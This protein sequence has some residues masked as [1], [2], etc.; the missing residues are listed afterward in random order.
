MIL[1]PSNRDVTFTPSF[2]VFN[3]TSSLQSLAITSNETGIKLIRYSISGPN[4]VEFAPPGND[5]IFV[6]LITNSTNRKIGNSTSMNLK[7]PI[8]CNEMV[9]KKCMA[10]NDVIV[11][12]STT[13]WENTGLVTSSS[14]V[15]VVHA[16]KMDFPM[17]LLGAS[18]PR[19]AQSLDEKCHKIHNS[20]VE[21][22]ARNQI[23][24][25]TFLDS[26]K[27]SF[28]KWLRV[29]LRREMRTKSVLLSDIRTQFLSGKE[30]PHHTGKGQPISDDSAFLLLQ[31]SNINLTLENDRDIFKAPDGNTRT[32][33]AVDLCSGGS[34]ETVILRA[35]DKHE[36]LI[37]NSSVFKRLKRDGWE[38]T[39][40]SLQISK[41]NSIQTL[42]GRQ[43]FWNGERL[44]TG[45]FERKGN[46]AL[47]AK[48]R[49]SFAGRNIS[50]LLEFHGTMV[51]AVEDLDKVR[52]DTF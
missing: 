43:R 8:G 6:D 48:L 39:V 40:Y 44:I 31:S 26:L 1:T 19:K 5:I 41:T 18:L 7:L 20:S 52:Y 25:K 3:S 4:A 12:S 35:P 10:S 27:D 47:V 36:N 49:K 42:F 46:L 2:L 17:S 16:G 14:G 37:Q 11:S 30:L 28:P 23:F 24:T 15:I 50:S 9:L 51:I 21:Q 38:M 45:D 29:T 32:S 33:L 34:P 13:P 22:L